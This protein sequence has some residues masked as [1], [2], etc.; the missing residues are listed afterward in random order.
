MKKLEFSIDINGSAERVWEALWDANSYKIWTSVF[1]E[2][3]YYKADDFSEG[4]KIHFLSPEGHGMYSVIERIEPNSHL[5]FRH[6]GTI[7]NFEELPISND[8]E[9]WTNALETY[10][11]IAT[12]GGNILLR[13]TVDIVDEY[14]DM[15]ND[16]FP[17]AL[18]KVKQLVEH[19]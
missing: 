15:M 4:G 12:D 8:S 1:S 16:A 18:E 7:Q 9:S 19:N 5:T 17:K 3:S 6:I 10:D 14:V 13:V 11:L 2:G